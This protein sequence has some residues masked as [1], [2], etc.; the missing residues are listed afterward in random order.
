[1]IDDENPKPDAPTPDREP[2]FLRGWMG[3]LRPDPG[4][5]DLRKLGKWSGI[6]AF[7]YFGF[8]QVANLLWG[9]ALPQAPVAGPLEW[10]LIVLAVLSFG[11]VA[12][13]Q[14]LFPLWSHHPST[15]G[16]RV[17]IAN[18]LYLNALLDRLI[19]GYRIANSK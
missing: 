10:A 19:C 4:S 6:V 12:V 7:A 16:L 1:M 13:A 17:H 3:G 2:S 18:G 15:A 5:S 8:Q 11:I 9:A 14:T